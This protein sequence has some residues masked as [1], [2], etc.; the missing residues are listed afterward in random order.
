LIQSVKELGKSL[1]FTNLSNTTSRL[2]S[3]RDA[4]YN[5]Y[6]RWRNYYLKKI[7]CDSSNCHGRYIEQL[8]DATSKVTGTSKNISKEK[9]LLT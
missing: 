7:S 2:A 9:T 8:A 5:D 4:H 3:T 1:G 6:L